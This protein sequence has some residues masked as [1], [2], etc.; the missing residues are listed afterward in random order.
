MYCNEDAKFYRY[1]KY[2]VPLHRLKRYTKFKENN[3]SCYS[4]DATAGP[5]PEPP[6]QRPYATAGPSPEPPQQ[7]PYSHILFP[8]NKFQ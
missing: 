6:Q 3:C 5:S 8:Q 2:V 7:R 4:H 1:Q